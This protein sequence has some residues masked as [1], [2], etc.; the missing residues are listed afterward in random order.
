MIPR[1]TESGKQTSGFGQYVTAI[2][3][4]GPIISIILI[5]V[6]MLWLMRNFHPG[7]CTIVTCVTVAVF[8]H[9]FLKTGFLHGRFAIGGLQATYFRSH[10]PEINAE[11]AKSLIGKGDVVFVDARTADAFERFH[12]PNAVSIPIDSSYA[13][14]SDSI[15]KLAAARQI[16]FYC[17][18]D[19]CSWADTI[20]NQVMSRGFP[21]VSVYRGGVNE[22]RTLHGE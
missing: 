5:A 13:H 16:V 9:T 8:A 4:A 10:I 14:L 20:G 11:E 1:F 17:Q 6:F 22:W 7:I 12:L 19:G 3:A 18:S 15:R 21:N 2:P